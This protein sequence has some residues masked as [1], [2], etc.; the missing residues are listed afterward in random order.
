M[1]SEAKRGEEILKAVFK[2]SLIALFA[3]G[4]RS[5]G[6]V[7]K[8][9]LAFSEALDK[10][11]LKIGLISANEI[12]G[13]IARSDSPP[14]SSPGSLEKV[15][16]TSDPINTLKLHHLTKS[17]LTKQGINTVEEL[18]DR[19]QK[20][21]LTYIKG[22]SSKRANEILNSLRLWNTPTQSQ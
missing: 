13:N 4:V 14:F 11:F 18:M 2:A 10:E 15:K 12:Q 21:P 6:Y 16:K 19:M 22:I 17:A 8:F 7:D 5:P 3:I 9:T 1:E 20:D